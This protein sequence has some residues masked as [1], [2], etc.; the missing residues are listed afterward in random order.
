MHIR[1]RHVFTRNRICRAI[2]RLNS[3]PYAAMQLPRRGNEDFQGYTLVARIS[4]ETPGESKRRASR[5][6]ASDNQS[7]ISSNENVSPAL[8]S[9]NILIEKI[10]NLQFDRRLQQEWWREGQCQTSQTLGSGW[11]LR[12]LNML[13]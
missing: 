10:N 12:F 9:T 7:L 8:E 1:T 6:P 2:R 11:S 5:N 13:F 4:G 3:D